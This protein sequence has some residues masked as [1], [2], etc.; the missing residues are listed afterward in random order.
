[1]S[2][3]LK[4]WENLLNLQM[5]TPCKSDLLYSNSI[6]IYGYTLSNWLC[7]EILRVYR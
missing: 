4:D 6:N 3:Q 1:M 5:K 2:K 7:L